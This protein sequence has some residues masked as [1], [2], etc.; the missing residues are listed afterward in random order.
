MKIPKNVTEWLLE[1]ENPSIRYRTLRELQERPESDLN[2]QSAKKQISSYQPVKNMLES[3]HPEGYW[4]QINPR[5]KKLG[6]F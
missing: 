5:S 4:E 6:Y 3:M 1:E 2:L